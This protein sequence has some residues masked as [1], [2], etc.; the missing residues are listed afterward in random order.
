MCHVDTLQILLCMT[1][2]KISDEFWIEN[3][4][5]RRC[6]DVLYLCF[7]LDSNENINIYIFFYLQRCFILF[8][9]GFWTFQF[10]T[11]PNNIQLTFGEHAQATVSQ[12]IFF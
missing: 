1:C 3:A 2:Q 11:K 7:V 10:A 6:L 12:Y 9:W 4:D 8:L 5:S